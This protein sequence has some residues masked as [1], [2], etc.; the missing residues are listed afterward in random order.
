[1]D[2]LFS[3]QWAHL[4]Y[5]SLYTGNIEAFLQYFF[6]AMTSIKWGKQM[7]EPFSMQHAH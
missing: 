1:M 3:M 7:D 4:H 2:E 5:F 6:N